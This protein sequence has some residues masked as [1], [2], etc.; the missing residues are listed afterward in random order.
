MSNPETSHE[1]SYD[2]PL[3]LLPI[4]GSVAVISFLA[5]V[6]THGKVVELLNKVADVF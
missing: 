4:I 3:T 2:S 5:N 6:A 1:R